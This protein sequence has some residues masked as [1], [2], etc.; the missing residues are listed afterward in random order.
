MVLVLK[1]TIYFFSCSEV[2]HDLINEYEACESPDYIDYV[3]I[4]CYAN[5]FGN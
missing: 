5:L 2:V 3:S 1:L 4:V